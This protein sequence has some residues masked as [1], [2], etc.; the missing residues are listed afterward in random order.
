MSAGPGPYHHLLV[1]LDG[2]PSSQRALGHAVEIA[3][4][5][6]ARL[7]LLRVVPHAPA[8]VALAGVAAHELD[9]EME[10][11]ASAAM[12]ALTGELPADVPFTSRLRHGEPAHEILA[13]LREGGYDLL[14]MG[15]RGLG[16]V[17]AVLLGSVSQRVLRDSP[18]EVAVFH[19]PAGA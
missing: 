17:G 8:R 4:F 13:E 18:V 10:Q 15:A 2:A 6:N 1:A 9:A 19:L 12:R 5:Y 14:L 16:R 3:R 11:E 7:T